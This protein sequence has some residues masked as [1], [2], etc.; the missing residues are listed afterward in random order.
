MK[1][2]LPNPL[3]LTLSLN[4]SICT[5]GCPPKQDI[6]SPFFSSKVKSIDG[7]GLSL[8][9][10]YFFNFRISDNTSWPFAS[11]IFITVWVK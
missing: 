3:C 8:L 1:I 6:V 7:T 11:I 9:E 5:N 4:V 10:S 2:Y